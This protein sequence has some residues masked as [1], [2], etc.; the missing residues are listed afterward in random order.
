MFY[1]QAKYRVNTLMKNVV[2]REAT[3]NLHTQ[4][5]DSVPS[6]RILA[7]SDNWLRRGGLQ[8][9]TNRFQCIYDSENSSPSFTHC[10]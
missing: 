4:Q 3:Y 1:L 2:V 9:K 6:M 7:V 8:A 10:E 5:S